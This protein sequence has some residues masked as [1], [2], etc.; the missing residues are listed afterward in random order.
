MLLL[1]QS[2]LIYLIYGELLFCIRLCSH[3]SLIIL[4]HKPCKAFHCHSALISLL[5]ISAQFKLNHL[6]YN[7]N[8]RVLVIVCDRYI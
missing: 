3:F 5:H 7:N 1:L 4:D 8:N 2:R 6:Y